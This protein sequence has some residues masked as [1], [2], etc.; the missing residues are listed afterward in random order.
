MIPY[1]LTD[2]DGT[3]LNWLD[4]FVSFANEQL[5]TSLTVSGITDY[6][7]SI[8][9]ETSKDRIVDLINEFNNG[10]PRFGE[11]KPMSWAKNILSQFHDEGFE[12]VA[13][14]A[15]SDNPETHRRRRENIDKVFDGIFSDV[16]FCGLGDS[17][18]ETLN[19]FSPSIWVEDKPEAANE[20]WQAGHSTFIIDREYNR[21][22]VNPFVIRV[23]DW[24]MIH[25]TIGQV[26]ET[27]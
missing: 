8:P 9:F 5:D 24:R 13:I 14:T 27:V 16:L 6:D 4:G 12:I 23:P 19:K 11:L 22:G 7:M 26:L 18:L 17:K 2:I 20:G 25:K 21:N 10:H 15:C 1:L 3:A